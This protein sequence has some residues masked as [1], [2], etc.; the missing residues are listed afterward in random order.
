[1]IDQP[2][3]YLRNAG[4]ELLDLNAVHG[5]H[6]EYGQVPNVEYLLAP[7][8]LLQQLDFEQAKFA[9]RHHE[10]VATPAGGVEELEVAEFLVELLKTG[11]SL[12]TPASLQSL[13]LTAEIIQEQRPHELEDVAL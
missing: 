11:N 4:R 12:R 10:E 6:I 2:H 8:Q 7:V 13:E 9:V 3:C 1:V 5:I